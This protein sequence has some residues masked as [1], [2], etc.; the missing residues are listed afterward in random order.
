LLFHV[1]INGAAT[2]AHVTIPAG[3]K[4][5][6]NDDEPVIHRRQRGFGGSEAVIL[7]DVAIFNRLDAAL[8]RHELPGAVRIDVDHALF[9]DSPRRFVGVLLGSHLRDG[10]PH[11][12][13]GSNDLRRAEHATTTGRFAP[14]EAL[15][16]F[17]AAGDDRMAAIAS[18][19]IADILRARDGLDEAF[20]IRRQEELRIFDRL[21]YVCESAVTLERLPL[22]SL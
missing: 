22:V 5:V 6:L 15:T 4:P 13:D 7:F 9:K 1:L 20:R 21:G 18:G 19:Q 10:L 16:T 11:D 2:A 12:D 17:E 14:A 8:H 3:A